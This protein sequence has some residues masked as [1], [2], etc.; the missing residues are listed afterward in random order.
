M[1]LQLS[2]APFSRLRARL[3]P[4]GAVALTSA[5][6]Y[7]SGVATAP[8]ADAAVVVPDAITAVAVSATTPGTFTVTWTQSGRNTTGF[9]LETGLNPF[10][11]T[12]TTMPYTGR[13]SHVF[14]I[15]RTARSFTLGA[16]ELLAAGGS[17]GS[18]NVVYF[19]LFAV[20]TVGT[21]TQTRAYA[22]LQAGLPK[23]GNYR[24]G[25]IRFATFNMLTATAAAPAQ[26][27]SVRVQKVAGLI[28]Y[29]SPSVLSAQ[30]LNVGRADGK[31]GSLNGT[32][33]QTESLLTELGRIGDSRYKLVR[34][35]AYTTPDDAVDTQGER[36]LYDSNRVRLDSSCS[37]TTGTHAYS[38]SCSVRL[39]IRSNDPNNVTRFAGLAQFTDKATGKQFVFVSVHLDHRHTGT[40]ADQ[41]SFDK[42]RAAQAQKVL[43]AVAA[44]NPKHLPVVIGGDMN[45][46]QN[47]RY[48]DS[49]HD[50]LVSNGFTDSYVATHVYNGQYGTFNNLA[51]TAPLG[52]NNYGT[53][54]DKIMTKGFHGASQWNNV[55]RLEGGIRASD[56]DLVTSD[57]VW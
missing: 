56:H 9:R 22:Y 32:P 19:R 50:L 10:S 52:V 8:P 29:Y 37:D 1:L 16:T 17:F 15:A 30:E 45:S 46:W 4:L 5:A 42:L 49:S 39:P 26:P 13:H 28:H 51:A 40:A 36:I 34:T 47:D 6:L 57:L 23:P 53:R 18:G 14:S 31:G 21:T 54:L 7:L 44:M 55:T 11:K 41:T 12:N 35:T 2:H 24:G 33:R 43:T 3:F 20:D 48:G 27:W 25:Q 38:T